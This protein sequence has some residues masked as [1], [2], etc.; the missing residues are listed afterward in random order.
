VAQLESQLQGALAQA[1]AFEA[2]HAAV[3]APPES[4]PPAREHEELL[5]L[6]GEVARLRSVA[7][8][9]PK[10][11]VRTTRAPGAAPATPRVH[12]AGFVATE[13]NRF[14]GF[15]TPA[16]GLASYYWAMDHPGSGKLLDVI[17]LPPE[18]GA[19]LAA[20]KGG[21]KDLV[22]STV[23]LAQRVLTPDPNGSGAG[24]VS[25]EAA[26]DPGQ[27]VDVVGPAGTTGS[28]FVGHRVVSDTEVDPNT[29]ELEVERELADGTTMT[30]KQTLAK[31]GDEW[32]V[33]PGPNM[34]VSATP[35]GGTS[36]MIS[37]DAKGSAPKP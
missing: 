16:D 7:A 34:N 4:Q 14:A 28:P 17:H 9:Q 21:G 8:G 24:P 37:I 3:V 22:P 23:A 36:V 2:K 31:V 13:D 33:Q 32:K 12:P 25:I 19:A 6:R 11:V 26:G 29:H 27:T 15:A 20:R 1:A 35:G 10:T 5:R 30:E 18:V